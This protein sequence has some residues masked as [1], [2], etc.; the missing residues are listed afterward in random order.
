MPIRHKI[1]A[2]SSTPAKPIRYTIAAPM[3]NDPWLTKRPTS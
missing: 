1:S 2:K 3:P